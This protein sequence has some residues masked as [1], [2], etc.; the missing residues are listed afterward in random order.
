VDNLVVILP[1]SMRF[2]PDATTGFQPVDPGQ[3]G[4][5]LNALT[6]VAKDVSPTKAIAFTIAGQGTL[7]RDVQTNQAGTQGQS[8]IGDAGNAAAQAD[9]RPGGGLGNPID[10][11]DPLDKYKW[12]IL[13]GLG[14]ALAIAAGFLLRRPS[15][16]PGSAV[17]A[18]QGNQSALASGQLSVKENVLASLKEELFALETD[19]LQGK[20]TEREYAEVKGSIETV[21]RRVLAR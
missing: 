18:A 17:A 10:T 19:R 6:F 20:V 7:P 5:E 11:P 3:S 13:S 14:I 1:K 9:T 16:V 8:D 4:Q 21:L 2:T 12:W 15:S